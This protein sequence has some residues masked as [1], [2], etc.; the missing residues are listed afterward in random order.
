MTAITLQIDATIGLSNLG[1]ISFWPI[2][3]SNTLL[4]AI[5]SWT[6]ISDITL[7]VQEEIIGG[8]AIVQFQNKL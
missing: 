8:A 5:K 4:I 2:I 3:S 1:V 7:K 6:K